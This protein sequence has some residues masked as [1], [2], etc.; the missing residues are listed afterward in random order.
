MITIEDI[1]PGLMFSVSN[2]H[3]YIIVEITS[4]KMLYVR[5]LNDKSIISF[6]WV[7]IDEAVNIFN[8]NSNF[9]LLDLYEQP[10]NYVEEL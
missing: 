6:E 10:L 5:Y 2:K 4:R 9:K 3:E 7:N 8:T 1:K